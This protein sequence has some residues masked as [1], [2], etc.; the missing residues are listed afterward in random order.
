MYGIIFFRKADSKVYP[1]THSDTCLQLFPFAQD[2]QKMC[3]FM[4][5]ECPDDVFRTISLGLTEYIKFD[6]N[7]TK[8]DKKYGGIKLTRC[9]ICER[10]FPDHLIKTLRIKNQ[11][12]MSCPICA[13]KRINETYGFPEDTPFHG[14]QAKAKYDEA[15]VY[16]TPH[17]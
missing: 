4:E 14:E 1:L 16:V 5:K 13:L 7:G 15:I 8:I 6:D 10:K 9:R 11:S 12:Y 3:K 2:A 17:K